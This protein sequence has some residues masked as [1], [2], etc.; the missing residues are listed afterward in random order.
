M[1][2]G[3]ISDTHLTQPTDE[4]KGLLAGPFQE[5]EM[6]LHAGDLT[7]L[8]VLEAFAGKKVFAVCGMGRTA[9]NR[10]KN[11]PGVSGS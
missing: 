7:E 5:V 8:A 2:I 9:G 11:R 10:R 3:V 1:K 6:V 4:L